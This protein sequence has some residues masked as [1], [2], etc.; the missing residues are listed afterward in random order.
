[1]ADA[2]KR[3]AE[4]L[5]A[6]RTALIALQ[7]AEGLL[8]AAE[9]EK[10]L[11][12]DLYELR[13]LP[14]MKGEFSGLEVSIHIGQLH[15]ALR[16]CCMEDCLL[17]AFVEAAHLPPNERLDFSVRSMAGVDQFFQQ[18]LQDAGRKLSSAKEFVEAALR[19]LR[20]AEDVTKTVKRLI[21]KHGLKDFTTG[22]P[23]NEVLEDPGW[24]EWLVRVRTGDRAMEVH[25]KGLNCAES[26]CTRVDLSQLRWA[27]VLASGK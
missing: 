10:R 24:V 6:K 13:F 12:E 11:V 8:A 27:I 26:K 23:L 2:R 22:R 18:L 14:L 16:R 5:A 15:T 3:L 7:R 25:E 17:A 1:M 21:A 19:E 20:A 4:A 9:H